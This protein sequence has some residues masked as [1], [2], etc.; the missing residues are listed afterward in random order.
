M[1]WNANFI[2]LPDF[3]SQLQDGLDNETPL[4]GSDTDSPQ[5]DAG[6]I[7]YVIETT[8]EEVL[9]GGAFLGPNDVRTFSFRIP[10]H[11]VTTLEG[12]I[13]VDGSR[14]LHMEFADASG[15]TYCHDK[16]QCSFDVYGEGSG[17]STKERNNKVS[18]PVN[19]GDSLKFFHQSLN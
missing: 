6:K 8:T 5:D 1:L 18:L 9:S 13:V 2:A 14:Y 16:S 11:E 19:G 10:N 4:Q 7:E 12:T 3:I 17:K 15:G